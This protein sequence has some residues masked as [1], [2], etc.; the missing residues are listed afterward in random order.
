MVEK[1]HDAALHGKIDVLTNETK[2]VVGRVK[3]IDDR[4]KVMNGKVDEHDKDI[5]LLKQWKL[6]KERIEDRLERMSRGKFLVILTA[7][8]SLAIAVFLF[9]MRNMMQNMLI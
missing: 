8:A 5:A 6:A 4:L 3:S 2:N 7:L 1:E 9:I